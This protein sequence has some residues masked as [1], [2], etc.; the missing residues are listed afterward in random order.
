MVLFDQVVQV[1]R[2]PDLRDRGQQAIG[3]DLTHRPVGRS[4]PAHMPRNDL[5]I[6]MTTI[7]QPIQTFPLAHHWPPDRLDRYFNRFA[8]P[9][10]TRTTAISRHGPLR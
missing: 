8:E 5:P 10:C 7:E 3:L 1:L 9:I 6:K 4:M 2:G